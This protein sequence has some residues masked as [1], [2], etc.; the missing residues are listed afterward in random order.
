MVRSRIQNGLLLLLGVSIAAVV[1]IVGWDSAR[2]SL[3][4]SFHCSGDA[5]WKCAFLEAHPLSSRESDSG[6]AIHPTRGWTTRANEV[7]AAKGFRITNNRGLRGSKDYVF[8]PEKFRVM[9]VGDSFTFGVGGGD[10]VVWP[11]VL[12]KEDE[13]LSVINLAV[14]GYGVDQMYIT[15]REELEEYRPQLVVFAVISEDLDRSLLSFRVYQ[16]P[17]FLLDDSGRLLLTNVPVGPFG[18]TLRR[19]HG[20]HDGVIGSLR[21]VFEDRRFRRS[22]ERGSFDS[23]R[24]TLNTR[25]VEE[26]AAYSFDHRAE[27][28]LLHLAAGG[29]IGL[30]NARKEDC[31]IPEEILRTA[32]EK[33]SI[34]FVT[35]RDAFLDKGHDWTLAHYT[36]REAL[37][38]AD[39]VRE[40]ILESAA[41]KTF[42]TKKR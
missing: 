31:N 3:R 27:F 26:A 22:I 38:V 11:S 42:S 4:A 2:R 16:K 34:H 1:L 28:M 5:Y 8:E 9:I 33:A 24:K 30:A 32:A 39:L 37:F 18:E 25:I 19:L 41:W 35:T 7:D 21:L 40:R 17:R 13:R 6:L 20:Q 15:L 10:E 23:E 12:Q 36:E 14:E 29:E